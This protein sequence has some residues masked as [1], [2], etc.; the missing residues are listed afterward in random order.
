MPTRKATFLRIFIANYA[1][2]SKGFIRLLKQDAL[3]IWDE[4]SQ[5]SFDVVKQAL[6]S[7][8]VISPPDYTRYV[9]LYLVETKS[10]LGMV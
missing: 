4:Q 9:S 2:I 3:F 6:V 1:E 7:T 5:C 10:T 8:P